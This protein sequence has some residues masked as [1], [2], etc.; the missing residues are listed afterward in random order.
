MNYVVLC[1]LPKLDPWV[2]WIFHFLLRKR[3]TTREADRQLFRE[4]FRQGED[5]QVLIKADRN[6]R[7]REWVRRQG[8]RQEVWLRGPWVRQ[9]EHRVN[10]SSGLR[11]RKDID[12]RSCRRVILAGGEQGKAA[13]RQDH[14][15]HKATPSSLVLKEGGWCGCV[16]ESPQNSGQWCTEKERKKERKK[17][18]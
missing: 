14:Q 15:G 12:R 2:R 10:L 13:S 1:M 6:A 3:K 17:E 18:K 11:V 8:R 7:K 5:R 4:G 16:G 9:R